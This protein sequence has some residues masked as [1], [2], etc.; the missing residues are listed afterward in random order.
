MKKNGLHT[1][2]ETCGF[3]S[4]DLIADLTEN[5]DLFLF[6][7]KHT[8]RDYHRDSTGVSNEIILANFSELL[9]RVAAER[10]IPRIP[11]IPGFNTDEIFIN[12]LIS[13]LKKSN[14]EGPV[15]FMPYHNWAGGKYRRLGRGGSF[16]DFD[17][18]SEM[19]LTKING[20]FKDAGF[21]PVNYGG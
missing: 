14:Y 6:D 3:F 10:I 2:V 17:K 15:H 1:A 8:N 7:I 20:I 9:D 18:M 12:D 19:E 5:V 13:F 16:R 4:K 21:L 11:L